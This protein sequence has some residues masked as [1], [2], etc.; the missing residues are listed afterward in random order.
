MIRRRSFL[1][2]SGGNGPPDTAWYLHTIVYDL[3]LIRSQALNSR[4]VHLFAQSL[5][6]I[7]TLRYLNHGGECGFSIREVLFGPGHVG[8]GNP[9]ELIGECLK[10]SMVGE[11][12]GIFNL[13]LT[14]GLAYDQWRISKHIQ[15]LT[16]STAAWSPVTHGSYSETLFEQSN[17]SFTA[18]GMWAPGDQNC[19]YSSKMK[20]R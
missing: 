3:A 10:I 16:M 6:D 9:L 20:V 1:V 12:L 11:E 17:F 13:P 5:S 8:E 2:A 15:L 14:D 19:P 18:M 7:K 4:L